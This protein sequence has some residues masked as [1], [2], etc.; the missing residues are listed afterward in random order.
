MDPMSQT[1][2]CPSAGWATCSALGGLEVEEAGGKG[3]C[4]L[5]LSRL[6]PR[7]PW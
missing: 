7:G 5:V 6:Q 1:P 3:P 4:L 2:P